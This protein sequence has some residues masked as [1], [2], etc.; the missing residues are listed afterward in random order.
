MSTTTPPASG[1]GATPTEVDVDI[2]LDANHEGYRKTDISGQVAQPVTTNIAV[3][4]GG[5]VHALMGWS[6]R[7]TTGAAAAAIRLHDG[8]SAATEVIATI[9]LA[10]GTSVTFLT[11][12]RGIRVDRGRIFLEWLSGSVEGVLYWR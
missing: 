6:L 1:P 8:N 4:Q 5:D 9:A 2:H 10:S 12:G 7:E 11:H 3:L